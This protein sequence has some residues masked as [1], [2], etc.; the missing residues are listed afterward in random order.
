MTRARRALSLTEVALALAVVAVM[1]GAVTTS[2]ANRM[3]D[4]Q[5]A[6]AI[7]EVDVLAKAAQQFPV[8][9][10]Q[11]DYTG[12][13]LAQLVAAGLAPSALAN[14]TAN[15]WGAGYGIAPAVSATTRFSIALD[16]LPAWAATALQTAFARRA[17][18]TTAASTGGTVLLT[19]TFDG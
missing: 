18:S 15:P 6:R 3:R 19:M 11:V 14:A 4:G 8:A 13:S 2:A 17:S 1:V 9:T 7:Q 5:L 12:L 16:G 10:G